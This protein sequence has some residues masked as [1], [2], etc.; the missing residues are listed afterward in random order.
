[1]TLLTRTAKL[2]SDGKSSWTSFIME[3]IVDVSHKF[4]LVA[5]SCLIRGDAMDRSTPG[6]AVHHQFPKFTQTHVH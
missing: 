5:Q 2:L 4:S 6:F 1:M 3:G